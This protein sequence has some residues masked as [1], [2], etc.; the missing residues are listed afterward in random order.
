MNHIRHYCA[1]LCAALALLVLGACSDIMNPPQSAAHKHNQGGL[2]ITVNSAETGARTLYPRT[3]FTKYELEFEYEDSTET[4]APVTLTGTDTSDPITLPDGTWTVTATGYV[5]INGT[6][7]PAAEGQATITVVSGSFQSLNITISAQQGGD[8]GFFTCKVSWPASVQSA[9]VYI[10]NVGNDYQWG[11]LVPPRSLSNNTPETIKGPPGYYMMTI[12]MMGANTDRPAV[13]WTEVIHIYSN[14][15]TR[16]ERT[17]TEDD[18]TKWVTLGGSVTIN[19]AALDWVGIDIYL[20]EY[21]SYRIGE[22]GTDLNTNNWFITLAGI[23]LNTTL[24]LEVKGADTMFNWF[25]YRI[26][27]PV[28]GNIVDVPIDINFINLQCT[29]DIK[30]K[31]AVI[32]EIQLKRVELYRD[33]YYNDYIDYGRPVLSTGATMTVY[34]RLSLDAFNKIYTYDCGP[35]TV[36]T[37]DGNV[38]IAVDLPWIILSGTVNIQLDGQSPDS[39][40]I[41]IGTAE[42]VYLSEVQADNGEWKILLP[43]FPSD[44]SIS[45]TPYGIIGGSRFYAGSVTRTAKDSDISGINFSENVTGLIHVS[46]TIQLP[47]C[48]TWR[49]IEVF[50]DNG[51]WLNGTWES[52]D[53]WGMW[54]TPVP[55]GTQLRFSIAGGYDLNYEYTDFRFDNIGTYTVPSGGGNISGIHLEH[56]LGLI[57]V[58]GTVTINGAP[59]SYARMDMCRVYDKSRIGWCEAYSDGTWK[60][61]IKPLTVL[62]DVYFEIW[63]NDS[64]GDSFNYRMDLPLPLSDQNVPG[65][66]INYSRIKI[67]GTINITVNGAPPDSISLNMFQADGKH[68]A[69]TQVDLVKNGG[70]WEMVIPPFESSTE[71]YFEVS[72]YDSEKNSFNK[73]ITDNISLF[74]SN[75][76]DIDYSGNI[77]SRIK[78]GGTITATGASPQYVIMW[79]SDDK[80]LTETKFDGSNGWE[81]SIEPFENSTD[82]YFEVFLVDN[83]ND[84]ISY[85]TKASPTTLYQ[86]DKLDIDF[87]YP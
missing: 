39:S 64:E 4:H 54:I 33:Q 3:V 18:L 2:Q 40:W 71:V 16:A 17:F 52:G 72:G 65:I 75:K 44:T 46:G 1:P 77:I 9:E 5:T 20:D 38:P 87:T 8:D 21:Y 66:N 85:T 56:N 70:K 76:N 32:P 84:V 22:A 60:I 35:V 53:S 45:L 24:Y 68:I 59:P 69:G 50:D 83:N 81:M 49:G 55:A 61:Y 27:V 73:K 13:T 12:R 57:T 31:G 43:S 74:N 79:T 41:S 51:V 48:V 47:D 23:E 82:V 11:T 37:A 25:S 78:I 14:M 36:N 63:G 86:S 80:M 62:T 30:I 19:G 34:P 15:E 28:T 7:Y 10:Y 29:A 26:P 6:E 42:G 67:G 58:S